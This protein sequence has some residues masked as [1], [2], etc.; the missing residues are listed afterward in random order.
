MQKNIVNKKPFLN[1]L[2]CWKGNFVFEMTFISA[3]LTVVEKVEIVTFCIRHLNG[4]VSVDFFKLFYSF[5]D[6][7]SFLPSIT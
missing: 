5:L 3:L 2:R 1:V 7:L 6:Q 4:I